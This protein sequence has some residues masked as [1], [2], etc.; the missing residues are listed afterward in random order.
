[1]GAGSTDNASFSIS[2]NQLLTA[3][4]FDYET[5][6]SYSVR[7]RSTDQGALWV[8]KVFTV[9][10][11][12]VNEPPT[13]IALSSASVPE[14]QASGTTV[15]TLSTTDPDTGETYTY[16]LVNG[17]PSCPGTDNASFAIAGSSLDTAASFDYEAKS[18]YVVCVQSVD[19]TNTFNKPFTIT[20]TDANEAPTDIALSNADVAENQAGGTAVGNLSTTDPDTGNTFTY[21]LVSGAGSTDNASFS[22]SGNQLLTA[23]PFDYETKTSYSVR[24]RSTDQG[25]LWFEEE[26]T[27]TVTDV[28]EAPT[29]ITI[30][31]TPAEVEENSANGTVVGMLSATDPDPSDTFTYIILTPGVPFA[32][33]GTD[34]DELQVNGAIDFETTPSYNLTIRVTDGDGLSYEKEFSVTVLDANEAPVITVPGAQIM[35]EDTTL[36]FSD[37]ALVSIADADAG[38]G[39][40]QVTLA[41]TNGT[42]SLSGVTGLSFTAG[43]GT[44]DAAMTFTGTLA[45]INAALNGMSFTP[46]ANYAGVSGVSVDVSDLGNT[47]SGGAQTDSRSI[48]ITVNG[49][50]DPPV[51]TLPD[52]QT[53]DEGGSLVLSVDSGNAITVSDVDEGGG[54]LTVTLTATDGL[55]TLASTADLS[56]S[57]GDG[58][59]DAAV[60][61]TGTLAAINAALDGLSFEPT[62]GDAGSTSL[63]VLVSDLGN[64]GSGGAQTDSGTL[65]ITVNEA[66][67]GTTDSDAG[68]DTG[69]GT[70]TG[71]DTDTDADT[72]G[73]TDTDADTD[74]DTDSDSDS[75]SDL[76]AGPDAGDAGQDGG[77]DTV[78]D[79]GTDTDADS[80]TDS[81]SDSDSDS[82]TGTGT[83]VDTGSETDTGTDTG[84]DVPADAS[85]EDY[86]AL[87]AGGCAGCAIGG[88]G[89]SAGP[90]LFLA[91]LALIGLAV[92][93]GRS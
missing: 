41:A 50:N 6:T 27:I 2:G 31:P 65:D 15:G 93:G 14:N 76:D 66:D 82:D 83:A 85:T 60:T 11:T 90:S 75:D 58:T 1:S 17:G 87:G 73:D 67:G 38:S 4:P 70:D 22:I 28:N 29:D 74:G 3:A 30:T 54:N 49:V 57:D 64:T 39:N 46:T 71:A 34:S 53:V 61:F 42:L 89:G 52:V 9:T 43:D 88:T 47:G 91:L 24:V 55:L 23:A 32:I 5:K 12:N 56:F 68:S 62:A 7:V 63:D 21:T 80:D 37:A 19:G 79:T 86:G 77:T 78:T 18:S 45:A 20:V 8:E 10:V 33:G 25:G 35:D 92:R 40:M 69:T 44:D 13:D 16:G 36:A 51:L 59:N 72:D 26:F 48:A 84:T 81:D